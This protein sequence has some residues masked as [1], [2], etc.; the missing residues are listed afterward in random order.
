MSSPHHTMRLLPLGLLLAWIAWINPLNAETD[1]KS[2]PSPHFDPRN[3][4]AKGDGITYDTEALQ[5][6]IDACGGTGGSVLLSPGTYLSAELTLH[7]KMT[8]FL[9]KGAVLLGGTNPEDYPILLPDSMK[10]RALQR[11][12]L[13]ACHADGLTIDGPGEINGQ[14]KLV[15][16]YGK[17]PERPSLIRIFKSKDITIKNVTLRN[18]RMWTQIYSE[19]Q[20]LMV[21]G[22]TVSAPPDCPNLDGI[23][24]CDS[25]DAIVRNCHIDSEDDGICLKSHDVTGLKNITIQN[26]VI[27]VYHANAIKIGT[28]TVGPISHLVINSNT[29]TGAKLGG[30]CIESVDGSA[31]SDISVDGLEMS[32]VAQPLFI[33][34]AHR[35]GPIAGSIDGVIIRNLHSK[36]NSV[37][38]PSCTITGIPGSKIRN[39]TIE[40]CSFEMPGGMTTNSAMPPEKEKIYPQSDIFG[41]IPGHAFFIRHA[42]GITLKN[43]TIQLNSPDARP[44]LVTDDAQVTRSDCHEILS[45]KKLPLD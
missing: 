29:I 39:V 35:S 27:H 12:L 5:K 13:Y 36:R 30:L 31:V 14:C 25:Q 42:E 26:N 44:W 34:L 41:T 9:E 37:N 21:D 45:N 20:N 33:R 10:Q 1:Q 40:N 24:V 16:M 23:D 11:S 17:E 3:Y 38:K 28:A 2:P 22:V 19:C 32:G 43:I 18:P 7:G 4:G 6:A 15:R 8:L